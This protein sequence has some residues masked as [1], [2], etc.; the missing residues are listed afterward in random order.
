M[1]VCLCKESTFWV[2]EL[3]MFTKN[4]GNQTELQR[5]IARQRNQTIGKTV[6]F[7]D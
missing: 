6:F 3:T 2:S 5:R 4:D 7:P 1:K